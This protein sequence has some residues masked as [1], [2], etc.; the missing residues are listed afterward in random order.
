MKWRWAVV[1]LRRKFLPSLC[2]RDRVSEYRIVLPE[3]ELR[4]ARPTGEEVK[5]TTYKRLLLV[6]K[7]HS[8][9]GL[10]VRVLDLELAVI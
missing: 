9:R 10:D 4:E 1:P 2:R 6:G 7:L 5:H 8:W 3:V